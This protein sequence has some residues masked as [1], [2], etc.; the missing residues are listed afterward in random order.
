MRLSA[1][2]DVVYTPDMISMWSDEQQKSTWIIANC[3]APDSNKR[4]YN[5]L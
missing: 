4:T 2:S 3:F 1:C 5:V